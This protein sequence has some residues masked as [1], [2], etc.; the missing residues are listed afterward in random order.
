MQRTSTHSAIR[1]L[2]VIHW[3]RSGIG[4]VVKDIAQ[5][6][7]G[8]V[9]HAL[10][11]LSPAPE[12]L[13]GLDTV[14][15]RIYQPQDCL[16]LLHGIRHVRRAVA[17]FEPDIIHAHSLT[18]RILSSFAGH[19]LRVTT[20]H[21]RYSYL[22]DQRLGSHIKR[23]VERLSYRLSGGPIVCVA[24]EIR[25]AL[26]SLKMRNA[27]QIIH[28]G[29]DVE[30][31]GSLGRSERADE[32]TFP[33]LVAVGRLE[34]EKRF[35]RLIAAFAKVRKHHKNATLRI[36]GDGTERQ[37]L[38]SRVDELFLGDAVEF[39]GH[40]SNPHAIVANAHLYVSASDYEGFSL[41]IAEALALGVPVLTTPTAG[42][43]ALLTSGIDGIV[44]EGFGEDVLVKAILSALSDKTHLRSL[45]ANGRRFAEAEC[46]VRKMAQSY[47]DVYRRLFAEPFSLGLKK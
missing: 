11:F 22:T 42:L 41:A 27:A 45:G 47:E 18:P 4:V 7:S 38:R 13:W 44:T 46:D 43:G 40:V 16:N 6:A 8:H 30:K 26:P 24:S 2:H 23:I 28:N 3:P 15:V 21:T 35:D 31:L 32:S 37:A 36:C 14:G 5:R 39:L 20:V 33:V 34:R 9:S 25:A 19:I 17:D 10:V 29:V 12:T 1:V